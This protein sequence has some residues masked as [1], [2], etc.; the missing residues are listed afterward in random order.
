MLPAFDPLAP[1]PAA[2][3][4]STA[5]SVMPPGPSRRFDAALDRA[6]D[7]AAAPQPRQGEEP[8]SAGAAPLATETVPVRDW[9]QAGS[10]EPGEASP[11]PEEQTDEV[12]RAAAGP[13]EATATFDGSDNTRPAGAATPTTDAQPPGAWRGGNPPA[14]GQASGAPG[15]PAG[16]AGLDA[17]ADHRSSSSGRPAASGAPASQEGRQGE[18]LPPAAAPASREAATAS[19]PAPDEG[20][21]VRA[22]DAG[23]AA[24]RAAASNASIPIEVAA[25]ESGARAAGMAHVPEAARDGARAPLAADPTRSQADGFGGAR[26]HA[27]GEERFRQ[28]EGPPRALPLTLLASPDGTFRLGG[29]GAPAAPPSPVTHAPDNFGRLVQTMRVQ[30]KDGISEATVRL[31]PEHLG[32]VN[33]SIRVDGKVV[34]AIVHAESAGVREWLQ[35][36]ESALRASLSEQG[37][38][39]D[40]LHVQRDPRHDRRE[41][42]SQEP[43]RSRPRHPAGPDARFEVMV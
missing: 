19:T 33:I 39:L 26:D 13:P 12:V 28:P 2:D 11:A 3:G 30:L 7:E 1:A 23:A 37:L 34:S 36:Q 15:T 4:T 29:A 10:G 32:E 38:Q 5:G 8:V 41:H 22:I 9:R 20:A 43:K 25:E 17:A 6:V 14:T 27:S 42:P 35:S 40:R 31:R 16:V 21:I 24:S 18:G